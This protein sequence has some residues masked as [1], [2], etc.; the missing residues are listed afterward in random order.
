MHEVFELGAQGH[1]GAITETR[2]DRQRR[3]T[4][5]RKSYRGEAGQ[6]VLAAGVLRVSREPNVA[7][8]CV[9]NELI[10]RPRAE[11]LQGQYVLRCW[12]L[13]SDA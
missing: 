2:R 1:A 10:A 6:R 7:V 13:R 12:I 9:D 5:R 3:S 11:E 8:A 4:A